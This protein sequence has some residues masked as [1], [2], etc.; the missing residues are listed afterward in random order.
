MASPFRFSWRPRQGY[1]S[2]APLSGEAGDY[3]FRGRNM[4]LRGG[5]EYAYAELWRGLF[6]TRENSTTPVSLAQVT[7]TLSKSVNNTL[8]TGTGT[9]FAEELIEGQT[10]VVRSSSGN[11]PLI[12]TTITSNTQMN[13]A[14]LS[15]VFTGGTAYRGITI[16]DVD[17]R[18]GTFERGSLIRLARG[19]YVGVGQG[20]VLFDDAGL[21]GTP[22]WSLLKQPQLLQV[23]PNSS[24][25]A[26]IKLGMT[27]PTVL[28]VVVGG[29]G[30]GGIQM[31]PGRYSIRIVPART[32]TGGFNNPGLPVSITL[33]DTTTVLRVQ[34][35]P[36]DVVN[37][38]DAWRV[39]ATLYTTQEAASGPWYY[40]KTLT[41]DQ[42]G[43]TGTSPFT[44]IQ[45][46][47]AEIASNDRL[48]FDNNPPPY[49]AY[50]TSLGGIPLLL[51]CNGLGKQMAGTAS[52]VAGQSGLTGTG[53]H[54]T[55]LQP[56]EFIYVGSSGGALTLFQIASIGSDTSIGL[57]AD[58]AA[59]VSGNVY[60]AND[61]P[62]PVIRPAQPFVGGYNIEAF[63]ARLAV[64]L[65]PPET[66]IGF[67][68]GIGRIYLLTS[69][70]LHIATLSGD[71]SFPIT[72]R[73]FWRTGFQN[74]QACVFVNGYLYGYTTNGATRSAGSGDVVEEEHSFAKPVEHDMANWNP[75]N[76]VIG[77]DPKNE[78][79][80]YIHSRDGISSSGFY[81]STALMYMLR[82]GRWSTPIRLEGD[83]SY[84][85]DFFVTSCATVN[86]RL[87]V[88]ANIALA[89]SAGFFVFEWDKIPDL[90]TMRRIQGY[91][92]SPFVDM[93]AEG[94][95]KDIHGLQIVTNGGSSIDPPTA[96]I[97]GAGSNVDIP[98]VALEQKLASAS[99][100]IIFTGS[101]N[102]RVSQRAK[103]NVQRLKDFS[104]RL[105]IDAQSSNT[106]AGRVDEVI[107]DGNITQHK[108]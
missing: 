101:L 96:N 75:G 82:L 3:I 27:A 19:H 64:A 74:P 37:G 2:T 14:S 4:I 26:A 1:W 9:L 97:Y 15:A 46:L 70:R 24:G 108:Y 40:V 107:I 56:G 39:Y 23:L 6:N 22:S 73:P 42:L 91:L 86:G 103:L 18:R 57:T 61:A 89:S 30:I 10:I 78:A 11:Y 25:L 45:Y 105:D 79:V 83:T 16:Q 88:T 47:D 8:V 32:A 81:Y 60:T 53:T 100:N 44:T 55:L 69:N 54:F 5:G 59:S 31:L 21:P 102:V 12:I 29:V 49:A 72:V 17:N 85:G 65:N 7:G 77:Y 80:V 34:F 95:D 99:G 62:G 51:G 87:F 33:T 20:T 43:G 38:Q 52:A 76:V 84:P 104:V 71:P 90:S 28:P 98:L 106:D 68:E 93:G 94:F 63:P 35:P 13:V 48:E 50:V 41:K 92:A 67:V 36:M 66:I 58:A